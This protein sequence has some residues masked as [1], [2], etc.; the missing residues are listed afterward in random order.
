MDEVDAPSD[1][2]RVEKK[3]QQACVDA[4][5]PG[6]AFCLY[7]TGCELVVRTKSAGEAPASPQALGCSSPKAHAC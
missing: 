6:R 5:A 3:Q 2:K 4:T 7:F 1:G